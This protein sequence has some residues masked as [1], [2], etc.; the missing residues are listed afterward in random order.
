[1][2]PCEFSKPAGLITAPMEVLTLLRKCSG[3]QPISAAFLIAW[4][5]NFAA[6]R[7][8]GASDEVFFGVNLAGQALPFSEA[9]RSRLV[10]AMPSF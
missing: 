5:A 9:T 3:F 4:A 2:M 8:V 7:A 10:M 1:M 6:R